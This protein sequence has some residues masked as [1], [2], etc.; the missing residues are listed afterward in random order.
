VLKFGLMVTNWF[1]S[2][3]TPFTPSTMILRVGMDAYSICSDAFLRWSLIQQLF[4]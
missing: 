4:G 1:M 2:G 3:H